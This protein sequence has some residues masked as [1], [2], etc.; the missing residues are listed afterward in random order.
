MSESPIRKTYNW[1]AGISTAIVI[2]MAAILFVQVRFISQQNHDQMIK[3]QNLEIQIE[4][5]EDDLQS[6]G[7][8][9]VARLDQGFPLA[10]VR[11]PRLKINEDLEGPIMGAL[12]RQLQDD[13]PYV[14][15]YGLRGLLQLRPESQRRELFAPMVVPAVIP[16][17]K[18]KRFRLLA[19]AV[20]TQYQRHAA[21]AVPTILETCDAVHW[22]KVHACIQNTKVMDPHCDY[23]PLL[24]RHVQESGDTWRN[25]FENVRSGFTE[26]EVL[27]AYQGALEQ[28]TDEKL[29]RRYAGIVRFLKDKPPAG[30]SKPR[31]DIGEFVR[32]QES[33]QSE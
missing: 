29:K 25:T 15:L 20:L 21:A 33:A 13:R 2:V 23:I 12:V 22:G 30:F 28:T 27:Q 18:D 9:I 16:K 6:E 31:R 24:I 14:Q 1:M 3:N 4:L 32:E 5:L 10:I 17:L 19:V 26:Q 7:N 11:G 8:R